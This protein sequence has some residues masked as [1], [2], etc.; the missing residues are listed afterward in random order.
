MRSCETQWRHATG[1]VSVATGL[2]AAAC[3]AL[4]THLLPKWKREIEE[5]G[6]EHETDMH[7]DVADAL[8]DLHVIEL[9]TLEAWAEARAAKEGAPA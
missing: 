9:A 2:D 7:Y 8:E 5:S 3:T 4:I 6:L 1:L